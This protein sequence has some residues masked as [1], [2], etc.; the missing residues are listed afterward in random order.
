[1]D[2]LMRLPRAALCGVGGCASIALGP[3][4]CQCGCA[5]HRAAKQGGG[6]QSNC[7]AQQANLA[8]GIGRVEERIVSCFRLG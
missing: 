1:M 8:L 5:L 6:N 4:N 3:Q 2:K 7:I